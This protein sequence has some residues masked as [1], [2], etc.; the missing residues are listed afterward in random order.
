MRGIDYAFDGDTTYKTS[1]KS[2]DSAYDGPFES[3]FDS[4]STASL[5][6]GPHVLHI[7]GRTGSSVAYDS[8]AFGLNTALAVKPSFGKNGIALSEKR[9]LGR[10]EL[11]F[12]NSPLGAG[13]MEAQV[14]SLN[15]RCVKNLSVLESGGNAVIRWSGERAGG[16][17]V[18]EGLYLILVRSAGNVIYKT[19]MMICR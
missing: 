12:A 8:V 17:K 18:S 9:S 13:G 2:L 5:T 1:L 4:L 3:F 10:I 15:G 6:I 16:A 14:F 19:R 7:R 11:T